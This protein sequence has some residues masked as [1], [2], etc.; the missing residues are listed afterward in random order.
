MKKKMM[1]IILLFLS[2]YIGGVAFLYNSIMNQSADENY[3]NVQVNE[4]KQL[5]LMGEFADEKAKEEFLKAADS[6]AETVE[7]LSEEG[8]L[9]RIRKV[10]LGMTVLGC[11]F[12]LLIFLYIYILKNHKTLFRVRKLCGGN[13]KGKSGYFPAL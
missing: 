11:L 9:I 2:L 7:S 13:C 8:Y 1:R 4:V 10:V 3:G 12:L 6:L 5:G